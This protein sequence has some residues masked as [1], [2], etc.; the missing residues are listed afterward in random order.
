M[1]SLSPFPELCPQASPTLYFQ[2][3]TEI[4]QKQTKNQG[5]L[6]SLAVKKMLF[7]FSPFFK[8]AKPQQ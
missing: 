2:H 7:Q 8:S 3:L 1:T 4:I 6:C 5:L